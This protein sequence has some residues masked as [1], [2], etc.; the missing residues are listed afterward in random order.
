M[1]SAKLS[2]T[3]NRA[4]ERLVLSEEFHG[5]E[6]A[7]DLVAYD[8]YITL[9]RRFISAVGV[10]WDEVPRWIASRWYEYSTGRKTATDYASEVIEDRGDGHPTFRPIPA[11]TTSLKVTGL[12]GAETFE[13]R[14]RDAEGVE[15]YSTSINAVT[16]VVQFGGTDLA[17]TDDHSVM[18][19]KKSATVSPVY[20]YAGAS[21]IVGTYERSEKAAEYRRYYISDLAE[22]ATYTVDALCRLRHMEYTDTTSDLEILPVTVM[23]ALRLAVDAIHYEDEG[24]RNRADAEMARAVELCNRQLAV[25]TGPHVVDKVRVSF[26]PGSWGEFGSGM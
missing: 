22:E 23:S 8:G 12:A 11:G 19:F 3:I 10:R 25:A 1:T 4:V 24:D 9:P 16:K 14:W 18:A 26:S 5:A 21:T 20:L 17:W 7:V 13:L 15:Q 6:Q 2:D